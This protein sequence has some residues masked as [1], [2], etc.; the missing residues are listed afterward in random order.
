MEIQWRYWWDTCQTLKLNRG[1]L[2]E[3]TLHVA[4]LLGDKSYGISVRANIAF[5]KQL[6]EAA[7]KHIAQKLH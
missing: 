7:K 2:T 1:S 5:E 3:S 6:L 4:G